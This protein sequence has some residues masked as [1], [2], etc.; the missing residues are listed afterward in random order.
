VREVVLRI[1]AYMPDL[2]C[3]KIAEAF[4]GLY[5]G[6]ESVGKTFV[7]NAIRDHGEEILR[8]RRDVKHRKPRPL[9]RNR[10]WGMDLT[11]VPGRDKPILGILDHGARAL[12]LLAEL[13][14]KSSLTI[15]RHFIAAARK[16]GLPHSIRTDNEK[17]FCSLT[18][19]AAL[20]LLGV[21]H[22]A[23]APHSPWQNGRFERL[24]LT[25]KE[26]MLTRLAELRAD[27]AEPESF[28]GELATF[29]L[30]YNH[31]RTHQ[32][33]DGL[34]PAEAW[35]GLRSTAERKQPR[36]HYFSTWE[37]LLTGFH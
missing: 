3:R 14:D 29:R 13:D 34:T 21:Q 24:F 32:H 15:L 12:L 33:L 36:R 22:Q 9:P 26:R 6:R 25:F 17:C 2:G 31:V 20:R 5:H 27:G 19:R 7:A 11:F 10:I 16:F 1:K 18:L 37:G 28:S 35:D 30:W 8:I 23:I 4:N